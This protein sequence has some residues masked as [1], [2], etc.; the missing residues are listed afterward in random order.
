MLDLRDVV[1]V[2]EAAALATG[3]TVVV[4]HGLVVERPAIR[5]AADAYKM[6]YCNRCS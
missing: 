3:L 4:D 6:E 2:E 5:D 1:G